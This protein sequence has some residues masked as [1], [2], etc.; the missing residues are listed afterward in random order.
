MSVFQSSIDVVVVLRSDVAYGASQFGRDAFI[1]RPWPQRFC[2][3]APIVVDM[4][5]VGV[6]SVG[7]MS[8]VR[9]LPSGDRIH[10]VVVLAARLEGSERS[11]GGRSL[12][13]GGAVARD[14]HGKQFLLDG[15]AGG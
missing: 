3:Y 6:V 1:H 4:I 5:R 15:Y 10:F 8:L 14:G 2:R 9:Q 13:G 7:V 12:R 11:L